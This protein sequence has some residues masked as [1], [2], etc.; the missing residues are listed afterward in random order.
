M[1]YIERMHSVITTPTFL[2]DAA[3]LSEDE[4]SNIVTLIAS[5]PLA[6]DLMPGTGGARKIRVAGRSHGKRGGYRV[7]TYYAGE[8]VPV[9]LLALIDKGDRANLSQAER[10]A[11]RQSLSTIAA[12]YRA[13]VKMK[14]LELRMKR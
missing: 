13:G 10:N 8:D 2:A 9:F 11:L 1:P 4:L 3:K 5:D 12:N 6:G 14:V 7:V